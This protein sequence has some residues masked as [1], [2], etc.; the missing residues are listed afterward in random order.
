MSVASWA[1]LAGATAAAWTVAMPVRHEHQRRSSTTP[2][3]GPET[4][5]RVHRWTLS[6]PTKAAS[7]E[8]YR[9]GDAL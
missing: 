3:M 2:A 5:R 7:S 4:R 9:P 8:V 1:R 6:L